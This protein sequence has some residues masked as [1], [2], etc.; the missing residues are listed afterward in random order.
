MVMMAV[1]F[2]TALRK[3]R[4]PDFS[5][6]RV[7]FTAALAGWLVINCT[8]VDYLVARNQV[9]RYLSQQTAI[10]VEYLLYDLS[11]DTLSQLER[12]S[13][14]PAVISSRSGVVDL[15]NLL[16]SRRADAQAECDNWRTWS[17]S[18]CLAAM[19]GR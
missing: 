9:D 4:K 5:F 1:F 15:E 12:L 16:S 18:A 3:L 11:Y 10:D 8:P 7:A 17:L 19:G 13:G 6:C 2:L 14:G